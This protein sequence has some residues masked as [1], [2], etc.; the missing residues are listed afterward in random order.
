MENPMAV[1]NTPYIFVMLCLLMCCCG[2][3]LAAAGGGLGYW[4]WQRNKN[5]SETNATPPAV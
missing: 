3:V 2:T 1:D 5:Q 4:L